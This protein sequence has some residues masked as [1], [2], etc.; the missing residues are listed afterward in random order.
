MGTPHAGRWR[1]GG[2][3]WWLAAAGLGLLLLCP[4]LLVDVPPVLDYPNHLARIFVLAHPDDPVLATLYAPRWRVLP[5][6][7]ID[8]VGV[9][10]LRVLPVHVAGRILLG[11]TLLLPVAGV[12]A[13]ARA[14]LGR[15]SWWS[16]A[17]GLVAGNGAFLLGMMNYVWSAGAALLATALFVAL[18]PCRPVAAAAG[19]ALAG[20]G[21][22][23]CHIIGVGFLAVLIGAQEAMRS[24]RLHRDG[25]PWR[26]ST[27][28]SLLCVVAA[29]LPAALLYGA[30]PFG[31]AQAPPVWT[32]LAAKPRELLLPFLSYSARV[33]LLTAAGVAFILG[34]SLARRRCE[35]DGGT[36]L[37][38]LALLGI[39]LAAPFALKGGTFL[40]ARLTLLPGLLLFAGFAPRLA[41]GEAEPGGARSGE[42]RTVTAVVLALLL[43]RVVTMAQAWAGHGAELAALRRAIAPVRPGER[44]L[45][46]LADPERMPD[47]P[48]DLVPGLH[49]TDLHLPAL[50]TIERRAFWPLLF[51]DPS[52]QPIAVRPPY[53]RLAQRLGEPPDARLLEAPGALAGWRTRWD[54]VLVLGHGGPVLLRRDPG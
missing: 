32:P 34:R 52:Q 46:V 44:V 43:L 1:A 26:R 12:M 33:T 30:S 48:G 2:P 41:P 51:A 27:A 5:N 9:A 29:L 4:L 19:C 6:L 31:L 40:D 3:A 35:L 54:A 25:Q 39:W 50:L 7:G 17:S 13:Y 21:V 8:L 47:G 15:W 53:D 14:V 16:L 28:I 36:A 42:V 22:F 49:R 20:V 10:L 38:C 23:F 37:A 11:I 24:H 18:R 45:A